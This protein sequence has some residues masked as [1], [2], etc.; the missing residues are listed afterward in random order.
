MAAA[1]LPLLATALLPS[2]P[3]TASP[4]LKLHAL[5]DLLQTRAALRG[6]PSALQQTLS[7]SYGL[8]L[9]DAE[10]NAK[11][12]KTWSVMTKNITIPGVSKHNYI[13][14]GIYNHP[15]NAQPAGCKAYPG[16]RPLPMS[17]CDNSTGLPWVPCDGIHN[18]QA[19]A[20]GDSPSQSAMVNAVVSAGLAAF[21]ASND[22]AVAERHIK[23]GTDV[24]RTWFVDNSTRML[25][26]LYYGQQKR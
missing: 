3:L 11:A 17:E 12:A 15:C 10:R 16:G 20:S 1:L 21:Y 6:S 9:E 4:A 25:P 14:I 8:V 19:I 24:L 22:S 23:Y 7:E 26:N 2:S 13:S 5:G 18:P